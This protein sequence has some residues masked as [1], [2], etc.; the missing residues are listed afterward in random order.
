MYGGISYPLGSK[1]ELVQMEGID[2]YTEACG[3]R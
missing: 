2:Q 1:K 3:Q